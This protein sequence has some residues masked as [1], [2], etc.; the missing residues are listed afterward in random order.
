MYKR[1]ISDLKTHKSKV[2]EWR[3]IY[4]ANSNCKRANYVT[5]PVS[6]NRL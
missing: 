2:E 6:E 5:K 3:K 4:Y 1:H